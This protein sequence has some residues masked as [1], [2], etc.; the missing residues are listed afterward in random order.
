MTTKRLD[1]WRLATGLGLAAALAGCT[2]TPVAKVEPTSATPHVVAASNLEAGKYLTLVGG[3]NDCHSPGYNEGGGTMP[4]ADRM[5]GNPVGMR[6]P[7][8][9]SYATNLRL[10]TQS[11]NEDGWVQLLK[12]GKSLPPMPTNNM[13][14]MSEGDLRALYQYIRSLGPKGVP[15]PENLPP[16]VEPTTPTENMMPEPPKA[17]APLAKAG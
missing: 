7:W 17:A 6:G 12:D 4:E 9:V 3:C 2:P 10:L 5:T 14:H 8:G 13:K 1:A 15:E 16:G 11:I